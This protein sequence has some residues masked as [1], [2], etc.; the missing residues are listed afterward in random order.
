MP[1]PKD[2]TGQRF[3]RLTAIQ[4]TQQRVR[5]AVIWQFKCDCGTII[6]RLFA[7]VQANSRAGKTPCCKVCQAQIHTTHGRSK[8][9]LYKV[10][11]GILDRCYNP[12]N[13]QW[14][15]Y[16]GRGIT[17]CNRWRESFENFWEDIGATYQPG[18]TI[19]RIDNNGPY[20]PENCRWATRKVQCSNTRRNR[21]IPTPEGLLTIKQASE[22]FQIPATTLYSRLRLG[23]APENLLLPPDRRFARPQAVLDA[24]ECAT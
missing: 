12:K 18:L 8:H 19:D 5:G 3:G 24:H 13:A 6:E 11:Q 23:W 7:S 16:G 15:D 9:P 22:R 14:K 1:Q 4:P 20:S 17:V 21:V 2:I 10:R